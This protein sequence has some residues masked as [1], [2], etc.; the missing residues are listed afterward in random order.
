MTDKKYKTFKD[1]YD[2]DE[3]FR[4]KH[5]CR[6]LEKIECECGAMV[7]RNNK[8]RHLKSHLHHKKI[9]NAQKFVMIEEDI[10]K[11]NKKILELENKRN[12]LSNKLNKLK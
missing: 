5:L 9:S 11:L 3:D 7:S 2:N 4:K 1:Y 6:M 12:I 10:I 8:S